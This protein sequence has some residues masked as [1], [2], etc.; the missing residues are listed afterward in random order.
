M[1]KRFLEHRCRHEIQTGMKKTCAVGLDT[2]ATM[3][4]LTQ[5][6]RRQIG[7]ALKVGQPCVYGLRGGLRCDSYQ[8]WTEEEIQAYEDEAGQVWVALALL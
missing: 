6:V 1:K 3:A 2:K 8:P 7:T 5:E 4:G